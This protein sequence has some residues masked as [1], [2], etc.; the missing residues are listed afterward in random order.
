MESVDRFVFVDVAET[1]RV[2]VS[3]LQ[4]FLDSPEGRH[5][6]VIP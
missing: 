4:E 6:L 1:R 3:Q 2:F 5:G